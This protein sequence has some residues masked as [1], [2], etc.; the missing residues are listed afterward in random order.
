[1]HAILSGLKSYATT[2][3]VADVETCRR[4]M[5]GHGFS[6]FSGLV[7]LYSDSLPSVTYEGEN[8]V[9]DKQVVR[10][11]RKAAKHGVGQQSTFAAFLRLEGPPTISAD[12]WE[13]PEALAGVLGWRAAALVRSPSLEDD[14]GFERRISKAVTEAF[15]ANQVLD[16]IKIGEESGDSGVLKAVY[17]LVCFLISVKGRE[18]YSFIV[19][20]IHNGKC[21]RRL[22]RV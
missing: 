22:P 12:T 6:A 20:T 19:P 18:P 13:N 5:G 15:V 21:S 3:S 14:P 16:I 17:T 8:Y 7:S 9:L 11:A 4:S 2:A 1:M 10:A